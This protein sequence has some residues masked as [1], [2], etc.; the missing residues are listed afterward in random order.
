MKVVKSFNDLTYPHLSE[1]IDG[2]NLDIEVLF[3]FIITGEYCKIK[4]Q[5][6]KNYFVKIKKKSSCL[7][8]EVKLLT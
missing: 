7:I 1:N 2:D 5:M 8:V 4:E 3:D 6:V